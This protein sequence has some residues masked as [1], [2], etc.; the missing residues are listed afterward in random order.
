MNWN[1]NDTKY[2]IKRLIVYLIIVAIG[3]FACQKCVKAQVVGD[4]NVYIGNT[5]STTQN[6]IYNS[7]NQN[8][9]ISIREPSGASLDGNIAPYYYVAFCSAFG[10]N[11]ERYVNGWY[12]NN[13]NIYSMTIYNTSQQCTISGTNAYNAT[14]RAIYY[15]ISLKDYAYDIGTGNGVAHLHSNIAWTIYQPG[16]TEWTLLSQGKSYEP[17]DFSDLCNGAVDAAI[18]NVSNAVINNT[19]AVNDLQDWFDENYNNNVDTRFITNM[20]GLLSTNDTNIIRSAIMLPFN[21]FITIYNAMNNSSCQEITFG[22][23]FNHE[24][25]FSCINI[26]NVVGSTFYGYIDKI[27]FIVLTMGYARFLYKYITAVLELKSTISS[28]CGVEVFK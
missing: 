24:L 10:N 13:G 22:T 20:N 12:D 11:P 3:F 7:G 28:S 19:N 6:K 27:F 17:Y 18:N 15:A 14:G 2:V 8:V 4:L 5:R 9:Q 26:E 1:N 23:W 25:K 16:S 21:C